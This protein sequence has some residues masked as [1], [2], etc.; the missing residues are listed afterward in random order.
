MVASYT[1]G[2]NCRFLVVLV[3]SSAEKYHYN[4]RVVVT[5]PLLSSPK[6]SILTCYICKFQV[7][8]GPNIPNIF[9]DS[10][11]IAAATTTAATKT[12]KH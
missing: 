4:D 12:S 3:V 2:R 10:G 5:A 6:Y 9:L 11:R 7:Y 8:Y 1:Y